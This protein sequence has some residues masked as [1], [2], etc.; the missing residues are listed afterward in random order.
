LKLR[1]PKKQLQGKDATQYS[2]RRGC[3]ESRKTQTVTLRDGVEGGGMILDTV[4]KLRA[5]AEPRLN[6]AGAIPDALGFQTFAILTSLS[7]LPGAC[8]RATPR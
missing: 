7:Q 8:K 5:C 4:A 2:F 6:G 3:W 1:T